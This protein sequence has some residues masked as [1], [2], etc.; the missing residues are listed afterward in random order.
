MKA[1]RAEVYKAAADE[2]IVVA[3]ELYNSG[4]YVLSCY[5]S[6]LSVECLLRA[7][8]QVVN[9]EFDANHDLRLLSKTCGWFDYIPRRSEIPVTE[10]IDDLRAIWENAHRFRSLNDYDVVEFYVLYDL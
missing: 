7:Y 8:R 2:H 3:A 4:R 10:A 9:A 6:G 1:F 5:V